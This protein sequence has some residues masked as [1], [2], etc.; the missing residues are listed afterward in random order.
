MGGGQVS[1]RIPGKG[2]ILGKEGVS[3][4]EVDPPW[5]GDRLVEEFQVKEG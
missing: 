3:V 5:E 4:F 1:W 2:R